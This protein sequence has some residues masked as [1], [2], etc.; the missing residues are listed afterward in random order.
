MTRK[1]MTTVA[2]GS[3]FVGGLAASHLA[4]AQDAGPRGGMLMMADANKDGAVTKAELTA[5][6]E[7]RFARLDANKDGKLDQADRDM[8]RQ[9]RLDKRFAAL[10]TDK[11]GQIS[12]AEF[13]A[14]HQGRDGKHD[15]MG[16]PGGPDGRGWGHRGWGHGMR[17]GPGDEM[18]KDGITKAEFLARPLALFDKADANHDGKVTAEEMKAARQSF[19]DGWKDRKAPTPAN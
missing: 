15:R 19:R 8:L 17:G 6:L 16:K 3:L 18:K 14:G 5:A 13:A 11:N 7:T 1:F 2:L 10:D 4:F 12:K 9:Q